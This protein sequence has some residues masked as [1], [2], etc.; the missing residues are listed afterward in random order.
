MKPRFVVA[1]LL[2]IAVLSIGLWPAAAQESQT[3]TIFAAASLTD[4][5]TEISDAFIA[6]HPGVEIVFNFGGSSS[7]ATQLVEGGAPADLFA[8]A[9]ARQMTVAQEG[10]RI[11][12]KP[13]TFVKNRL[14]LIVPADNPAAIQ[15]LRDLANGG[16]KL[17]VAAEGVPVRDYTNT[18]LEGLAADPAYGEGYRTAVIANIVSEEENVRQV[19]A[20]VAL[21]EADAGIV[22]RSDVTPDIND[23]VIALPIPD[24]LNTIATYPIAITN[25]SANPELAQQFIDYLLSDIGQDTLVEWN[26][27]SVRIPEL[28]STISL[29]DDG[30]V[31]I[32][33]QLLN[34]FTL[35]VED[36]RANYAPQTLDVTYMSGEDTV[37]TT[38]TGVL[39]W[40]II[41]AAQ[42]N[43]N[44][45]VRN[46]KLS[47]FI[48]ATGS[49]GY[50]AVI[51]WGEIDP[52][53]GN[54]PILVAFEEAG[55]PIAEESGG[56][57]QLVIPGDARGGRYVSG[58]V[59]LSLRDAPP[60]AK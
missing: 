46:D 51:A 16:V 39:L 54:Q 5:F 24:R 6:D 31:H 57:I 13:M 42:P 32:N 49:D 59:D 55:S 50:Q 12:G 4:A 22:Y 3:L 25:D 2:I 41:S 7:L 60:V 14:V 21:G 18:L 26:F 33:G 10:E 43:L 44:A 15:S 56:A 1:C 17:V 35:T 47:T 30:M 20:K 28:P 34:P 38:F 11:A 23:Q 58:L 8:S 36:L 29:L 9:N 53:F 48:V 37:S 19:S 40:D 27:I 52:E 45:D